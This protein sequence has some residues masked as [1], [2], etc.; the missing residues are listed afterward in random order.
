MPAQQF[1]HHSQPVSS[2]LEAFRQSEEMSAAALRCAT[3]ENIDF[4]AVNGT[5]QPRFEDI[6]RYVAMPFGTPIQLHHDALDVQSH[7]PSALGKRGGLILERHHSHD[8]FGDLLLLFGR[9]NTL[10]PCVNE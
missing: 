6:P 7:L 1:D 4:R 9:E 5:P 8:T 2:F 10:S 3:A